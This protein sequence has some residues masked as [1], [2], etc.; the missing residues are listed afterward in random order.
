VRSVPRISKKSKLREFVVERGWS[1]IGDAE[2]D[3]IRVAIP[4]IGPQDLQVLQIPVAPPWCGVR[5]HTADE[6]AESLCALTEVYCA[7]EDLRRFC[8]NTVILAKDRARWASRN[9]RVDEARQ[10][11]KAEMVQWMLVWLGDPAVFPAWVGIRRTR[12]VAR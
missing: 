11:L 4:G 5:Q 2:W 8:R 3:E 10:Q 1:R 12:A 9:P 6:L 7:R